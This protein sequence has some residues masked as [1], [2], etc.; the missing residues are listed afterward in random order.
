MTDLVPC[1]PTPSPRQRAWHELRFYGFLHFTVNT[2]TDREWGYGDESPDLFAPTDFDA[3]Q[4]V[5]VARDG[6]MKGLILT[7]KHHDG[8]CLWPTATTQHS[9]AASSWRGGKGD[10]VRD[11]AAAC[12]R[13][14]LRFGVYLSPWDRNHAAYGTPA[15]VDVYRAQLRELLTGYGPI[16]EVWHDGANGGDGFYGG[17]RQTR[18]ID[19]KTYYD[20][21]GTWEIVRDLQPE[22]VIFSDV[23]P[24]V[25]WVGNESGQGSGTTWLTMRTDGWSPGDVVT[26]EL[27]EGHEGGDRWLPPEVDVSIRPGWFYHAAEDDRVKSVDDLL[28]IH[29][30]SIGRSGAWLLNLPPTRQGRVHEIDARHLRGLRRVLDATYGRDLAAGATV[31]ASATRA[32]EH[33]AACVLDGDGATFW[34]APDDAPSAWIELDLGEARSFD[35]VLCEE[36]IDLGQRVRRWHVEAANE[37]GTWRCLGEATT[38]GAH[39]ILATAPTTARRVRLHIDDARACPLIRRFSLHRQAPS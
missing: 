11:I 8:F 25:R 5:E 29:D 39:R 1:G 32:D 37:G 13:H 4:I 33:A 23:G 16:F 7:C 36:A 2:F 19:K 6:G 27:G 22:A 26:E 38:I 10:V 17:A 12:A 24:D 15:Y 9:V 34:A 21:P 14:G 31:T 18:T 35:R 20:W 3:D 28:A 30:A